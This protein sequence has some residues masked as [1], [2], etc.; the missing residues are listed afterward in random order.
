M[1]HDFPFEL[2]S[3]T[4][5]FILFV[6]LGNCLPL[7]VTVGSRGGAY[8][9]RGAFPGRFSLASSALARVRQCS[10]LLVIPQE[11]RVVPARITSLLTLFPEPARTSRPAPVGVPLFARP[12]FLSFL[13]TGRPRASG[14]IWGFL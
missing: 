8:V 12:A 10:R 14:R 1:Q 2:F 4:A 13:I 3:S 5:K 6:A 7:S 11:Q 9:R